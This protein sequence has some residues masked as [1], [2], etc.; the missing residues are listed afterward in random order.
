MRYGC[1]ILGKALFRSSCRSYRS[2]LPMGSPRQ[3]CG[4]W[5]EI[6]CP[7]SQGTA[8]AALQVST[9]LPTVFGVAHW[10]TFGHSEESASASVR[11]SGFYP[12]FD[13]H[14]VV[15]TSGSGESAVRLQPRGETSRADSGRDGLA[16]G[17]PT[18]APAGPALGFR[19]HSRSIPL[20]LTANLPR[21]L[22]TPRTTRD[23]RV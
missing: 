8:E 12:A 19:I 9:N 13:G 18:T 21:G 4:Q 16:L 15:R 10:H 17:P 7:S 6:L 3:R 23:P 20:Q 22:G 2:S 5:N 11:R 14:R 1:G